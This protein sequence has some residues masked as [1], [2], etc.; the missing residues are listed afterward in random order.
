VLVTLAVLVA[1]AAVGVAA[2]AITLEVLAHLGKVLLEVLATALALVALAVVVAVQ[3]QRVLPHHFRMAVM[4]VLVQRHPSQALLLLTLV[5]VVA[6]L[7]IP[8]ILLE[9]VVLVVAVLEVLAVV[10]AQMELQILAA[11]AGGRLTHRQDSAGSRW[12]WRSHLVYSNSKLHRHNHRLTNCH[13]KRRK[14]N[15]DLHKFRHIHGIRRN[16]C[17]TLQK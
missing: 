3:V 5:A 1:L 14:H 9:L 6:V 12:L 17:H 10:A 11:V 4:A 16:K 7:E 13:H 15:S 8:Q 2:I